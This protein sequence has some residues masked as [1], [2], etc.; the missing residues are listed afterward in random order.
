MTHQRQPHRHDPRLHQRG[1]QM[2]AE[3]R[4][5][6]DPPAHPARPLPTGAADRAPSAATLY[7]RAT[8]MTETPSGHFQHRPVPLLHRNR[9]DDLRITRRITAVHGRPDGHTCPARAAS[10]YARVRGSPGSLLANPLARSARDHPPVAHPPGRV[11]PGSA[12]AEPH[13]RRVRRRRLRV[14]FYTCAFVAAGL[15]AGLPASA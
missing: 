15:V 12:P 1:H 9:T 7:R 14:G 8:S 4:P 13:A 3:R 6:A 11:A 10:R 5:K 2:R